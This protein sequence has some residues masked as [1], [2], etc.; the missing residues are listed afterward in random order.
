MYRNIKIPCSSCYRV[1]SAKVKGSH[2]CCKDE[3][4]FEKRDL[5]QLIEAL[6]IPEVFVCNQ[7]SV[8]DGLEGL[9]IALRRFAYPCRYSDLIPR[10]GRPV[11]E[12][13][14]ISTKVVDFIYDEHHHRLTQWK[15]NLLNPASMKG[16][17][18]LSIVWVV[19]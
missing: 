18:L 12:I 19:R 15:N 16:T 11:P 4:R 10:F 2:F 6:G 7:R 5:P 13:S 14:T 1:G 9:C 3:F 8:C 17:Q